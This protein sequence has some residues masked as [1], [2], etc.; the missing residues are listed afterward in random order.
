M[1]C[2]EEC[3]FRPR[4]KATKLNA[5]LATKISRRSDVVSAEIKTG[6]GS[7]LILLTLGVLAL[8]AG[9]SWIPLLAA[10]AVMVW[11]GGPKLA[12][13]RKGGRS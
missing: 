4:R 8:Y 3:G 9:P 11:Y 5:A 7:T 12:G 2:F 6:Y 1:L 13:I 10:A